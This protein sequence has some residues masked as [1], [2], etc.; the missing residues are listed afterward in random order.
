MYAVI[1]I[2]L[3][4]FAILTINQDW[5]LY[6]ELLGFTYKPWRLFL[7]VCAIPNVICVLTLIFVIPESPKY[8]FAQGNEE[9]TL[10]I[11]RRVYSMNTGR[12][13]ESF[14]VKSIIKDEEFMDGLRNKSQGFFKFMWSQSVP[15]FKGTHLKNILTACFIQFSVCNA[16]NG[17][18]TFLPEFL[19]KISLWTDSS[20]GPATVCEIFTEMDKIHNHTDSTL[21]CVQKLQFSTFV[22]I[23]EIAGL[24]GIGYI[25][26]S[27]IVKWTGKLVIITI[28]VFMG[29][30]SAFLLIYLK[31]PILS[32][33]L[34]IV[35]IL[36]GLTITVTHASTIDLFP[37]SMRFGLISK[38]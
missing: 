24:F 10:R 32:S 28:N 34:Y 17:F 15:L 3:P 4:L 7:V 23:F 9:E 13:A 21:V 30:V 26:M 2:L 37:T 36:S 27:S 33:Y 35:M 25:V 14:D 38:L 16:S 22:Y 12:F 19:N 11:L 20:R 5:S 29:G 31:I 8:T 1:N 6:I 18:W